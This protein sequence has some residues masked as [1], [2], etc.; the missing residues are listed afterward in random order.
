MNLSLLWNNCSL[1]EVL[2]RALKLDYC[3]LV[4]IFA[5]SIY[6]QDSKK[7]SFSQGTLDNDINV[8]LII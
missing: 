6:D 1:L 7:S 8:F 4:D 2:I 3:L 5:N